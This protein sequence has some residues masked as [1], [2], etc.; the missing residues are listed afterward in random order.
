MKEAG[1]WDNPE[2]KAKMIKQFISY[3]RANGGRN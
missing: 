3:D 1:A 2:R